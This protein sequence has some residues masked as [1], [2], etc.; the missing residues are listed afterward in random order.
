MVSL[1]K[2]A[3]PPEGCT[4]NFMVEPVENSGGHSHHDDSRRKGTVTPTTLTI[5]GGSPGAA[6]AEY[7]SSEV[8]GEEKIIA[9][10][11]G[12]N[13][14]E[15]TVKVKVP[16]LSPL[17]S[18]PNLLPWGGTAKHKLGDNNY[19]TAYTLSAAYYAVGKYVKDHALNTA[20]D[21]YLAVIDMSLPYGGLFDINGDWSTPHDWHRKGTSVD[22]SKYY[23]DSSGNNIEVIFYDEDG[24]VIE[25]TS[26]I[27][28]TWLDKY[29]EDDKYRCS[30]KERRIGKIHYE[31]SK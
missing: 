3:T 19:G 5:P 17:V 13:K 20:P 10:I 9:E 12:E 27:D 8:A 28:D 2:P 4:A 18:K 26:I 21:V 11:K 14:G 15:T 24:N 30:R 29:F 22:F 25:A 7:K 23:K 1:N 31:C 6:S 16:G